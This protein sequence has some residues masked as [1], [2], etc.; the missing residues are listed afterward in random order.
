MAPATGHGGDAGSPTPTR[1]RRGWETLPRRAPLPPRP[2]APHHAAAEA[3]RP[4]G[5]FALGAIVV[6]YE[7]IA[8]GGGAA[9]RTGESPSHNAS[10]TGAVR[11]DQLSRLIGRPAEVAPIPVT[12]RYPQEMLTWEIV[13]GAIGAAVCAGIVVALTPSPWI[14]VPLLVIAGLFGAYL[15]QQVRR[16]PLRFAVDDT[17]VTQVNGGRRQPF[18]WNELRDFRLNYYPNGRKASMGMLVLVLRNGQGKLKVDSSLD[19]FPTLLSRAAQAA[20]ERD[21]ELHPTTQANLAQLD[22]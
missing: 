1:K 19:H 2:P 13:K 16:L 15:L 8:G 5:V 22:L 17:G 12:G 9:R 21:L 20:R 10:A 11:T 7:R 6:Q 18:R 3:A 14:G 4:C